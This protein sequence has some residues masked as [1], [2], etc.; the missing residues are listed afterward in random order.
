MPEFLSLSHCKGRGVTHT[1]LDAGGSGV[2][3]EQEVIFGHIVMQLELSV[4]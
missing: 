2:G 1:A 3:V 4:E